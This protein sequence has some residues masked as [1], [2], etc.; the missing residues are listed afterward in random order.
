[1]KRVIIVPVTETGRFPGKEILAR[2]ESDRSACA[3]PVRIRVHAEYRIMPSKPGR[4]QSSDVFLGA[5]SSLN[6]A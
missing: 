5:L 1:M 3:P 2:G 6:S 4:V